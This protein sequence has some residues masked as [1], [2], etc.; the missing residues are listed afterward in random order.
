MLTDIHQDDSGDSGSSSGSS[1]MG[2]GFSNTID[3]G[4]LEELPTVTTDF[5]AGSIQ[6]F[7]TDDE[8]DSDDDEGASN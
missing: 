7:E 5:L 4:N 8:S 3:L 6:N 2:V 1:F